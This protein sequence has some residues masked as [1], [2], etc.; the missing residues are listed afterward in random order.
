MFLDKVAVPEDAGVSSKVLCEFIEGFDR[1]GVQNHAFILI[2]DGKTVVENYTAPFDGKYAHSEFSVSKGFISTAVGFAI[3][4]GKLALDTPILNFYPEYGRQAAKEPRNAQVTVKDLLTMCSNKKCNFV[5]DMTKGD[6]AD[7]WIGYKFRKD[8]GFE[9]SNDD[10]Y[11]L[12]KAISRIYG[13]TVV[14]M[15]MPRLFEPLGIER[16]FWEITNEGIEAAATGLRLRPED[17]AKVAYCYLNYGKWQDKQV[18]PR[19]WTEIAGKYYVDLPPYYS[20]TTKYGF[21]FW[22]DP[23]GYYRFDGMYGQ[24]AWVMPEHNAVLVL[25]DTTC[26]CNAAIDEM[27]RHFPRA[28]TE[29]IPENVDEYQARLSER[30]AKNAVFEAPVSK[31]SPLEGEISQYTYG[32]K[33]Y[34]KADFIG[35]PISVLPMVVSGTYPRK[36]K[37][38]LDKLSLSFTEE[39]AVLSWQEG[40]EKAARVRDG[41]VVAIEERVEKNDIRIGLNGQIAESDVVLGTFPF[42][43][44]SWGEWT[45]DNTLDVTIRFIETPATRILRFK[46]KGRHVKM[47]MNSNPTVRDFGF[48]YMGEIMTEPKGIVKAMLEL[49][50]KIMAPTLKLRGKRK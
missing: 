13:M 44:L 45:S 36:P 4:E 42:K 33:K 19:E 18:I 39:G 47:S 1:L 48:G 6:Y 8:K 20:E 12:A 15:L 40:R 22:G 26:D 23:F 30:L 27:F 10:V 11:M 50:F 43:T 29:E 17:L 5:K 28:F 34:N 2:K 24:W 35:Y 21:Y 3:A 46:F 32:F 9:Y 31:R 49:A 7:D 14:D 37:K 38:S 41:K 25:N 16:P